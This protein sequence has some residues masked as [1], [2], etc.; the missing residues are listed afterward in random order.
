MPNEK[1]FTIAI[2]TYNRASYLDVCLSNI[3]RQLSGYESRIELIVSNNCSTDD[4]DAV[5]KR[6]LEQGVAIN[7]VRNS[8]NIGVD[9]NFLQCFNLARGKYVVIFGD[10]DVFLE[11]SLEAIMKLLQDDEYGL[12][13][14]NSYAYRSDFVKEAPGKGS[15]QVLKYEEPGDFLKKVNFWITFASGNVFNKSLLPADFEPATFDGTNLI[16]VYWF[17][18]ALFASQRSAYVSEQLIAVKTANTG[19]YDLSNVFARNFNR[20]FDHFIALGQPKRYFDAIN[21]QLVQ[22]FFPNMILIIR[23]SSSSFDFDCGDF[24]EK[25]TPVFKDYPSYWLV[26]VPVVKLP[27]ALA[28]LYYL[29][30]RVYRKLAGS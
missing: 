22:S 1:L 8:E 16:Q 26:T 4:T 5:V 29:P 28:R 9:R 27:V 11:G 23:G 24:Y 15:D 21:R 12:V 25:L 17:L 3:V 6:Y 18:S 13:Y 10:D 30:F 7:Y 20:L 2:P 14:V 19:G